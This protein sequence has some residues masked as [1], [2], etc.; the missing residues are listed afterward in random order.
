MSFLFMRQLEQTL[1]VPASGKITAAIV[2]GMWP[3]P[4]MH[5]R[6]LSAAGCFRPRAYHLPASQAIIDAMRPI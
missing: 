3:M 5:W 4:K 6:K 1:R 2:T